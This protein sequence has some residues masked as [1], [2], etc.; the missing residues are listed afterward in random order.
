MQKSFK[1]VGMIAIVILILVYLIRF[2]PLAPYILVHYMPG[3]SKEYS[4]I[5]PQQ[6]GLDVELNQGL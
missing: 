4:D 1:L 6:V 3:I 5:F 2:L